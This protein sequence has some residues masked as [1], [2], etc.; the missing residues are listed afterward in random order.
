MTQETAKPKRNYKPCARCNDPHAPLGY[1]KDGVRLHGAPAFRRGDN[2]NRSNKAAQAEAGAPV[3]AVSSEPEPT[4]VTSD[5]TPTATASDA[6]TVT[7]SDAR[8]ELRT[9]IDSLP[10]GSTQR[11]ALEVMLE[12]DEARVKHDQ[13][14]QSFRATVGEDARL[15]LPTILREKDEKKARVV[16]NE[17]DRLL[18]KEGVSDKRSRSTPDIMRDLAPEAQSAK[19]TLGRIHETREM[20]ERQ[21]ALA[22]A[23]PEHFAGDTDWWCNDCH[24]G[25]TAASLDQVRR[26]AQAEHGWRFVCP[27]CIGVH[28]QLREG[29]LASA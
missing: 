7:A 17:L 12:R 4:V 5:P 19:D 29:M 20:T 16:L 2:R 21:A 9:L 26:K 6:V 13:D 10:E 23:K 22:A 1:C 18:A 3:S 25:F 24:K 8:S 27:H 11:K 28:V 15:P 14:E